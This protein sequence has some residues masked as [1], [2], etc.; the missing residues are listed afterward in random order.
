MI[1]LYLFLLF[2]S[3]VCVNYPCV[4]TFHGVN[5]LR[6]LPILGASP[7]VYF[8]PTGDQYTCLWFYSLS[9]WRTDPVSDIIQE[10]P[11]NIGDPVLLSLP[12][13]PGFWVPPTTYVLKFQKSLI[14]TILRVFWNTSTWTAELPQR[15]PDDNTLFFLIKHQSSFVFYLLALPPLSPPTQQGDFL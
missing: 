6:A 8:C 14:C 1:Y 10:T 11:I 7:P 4:L 12:V 3:C 9:E 2:Y 13:T 15:P 5:I